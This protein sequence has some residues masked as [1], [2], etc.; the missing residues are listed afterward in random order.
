[1]TTNTAGRKGETKMFITGNTHEKHGVRIGQYG[2]SE[3]V[4]CGEHNGNGI[5]GWIEPACESLSW[6]L[7]FSKN[8]D[9]FLYTE[10]EDGGAV[11]G[12]PIRL[13]AKQ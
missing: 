5:I 7:W 3:Q 11:K 9:G 8:G 13:K 10:R 12:E 4:D 1:V 2:P 6:I